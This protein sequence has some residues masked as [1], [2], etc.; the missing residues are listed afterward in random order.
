MNNE[1]KST[2]GY[3][4]ALSETTDGDIYAREQSMKAVACEL[5]LQ[6]TA[7]YHE[8]H[9]GPIDA[10]NELVE[11]I[12]TTGVCTVIVPSL[13]DLGETQYL[14]NALLDGL[15]LAFSATVHVLDE[16]QVQATVVVKGDADEAVDA[17]APQE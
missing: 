7:I 5:G 3:M 16:Q 12:H 13:S 4:R 8:L 2:L 11:A 9:P 14:Q 6:L 10:F 17:T 1:Q 15:E